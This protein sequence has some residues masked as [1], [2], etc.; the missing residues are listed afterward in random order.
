MIPRIRICPPL[1]LPSQAYYVIKEIGFTIENGQPNLVKVTDLSGIQL[2]IG[3]ATESGNLICTENNVITD[4]EG[5][6]DEII[7]YDVADKVYLAIS[8]NGGETYGSFWGKDMNF[9]GNY[10]SRFRYQR[11]GHA[12]DAS[13]QL[14][15]TGTSR[16]VVGDGEALIYE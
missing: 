3:L 9:T 2:G 13:I 15:F 10:I 1:R 4:I 6:Q 16:F 7:T 11:C 5:D 12:N 14:R 8:R